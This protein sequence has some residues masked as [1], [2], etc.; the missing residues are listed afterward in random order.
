[1][2]VDPLGARLEG[3]GWRHPGRLAWAVRNATF[4]ISPG[5]RVLIAGSSGSG[6]S[7]LVRSLG[8]L[9]EPTEAGDTEGAIT[10]LGATNR[11]DCDADRRRIGFMLQDPETNLLLTKVGDDVAFGLENERIARTDIW[12]R[13]TAA[14]DDVGYGYE[15]DRPTSA[16]SGG[17]KQRVALAAMLAR[18]SGLVILDEPTAN[19]D[20]TGAHATM[21]ALARMLDESGATLVIIEHRWEMV[22]DL[23]DRVIVLTPGGVV[24]DGAPAEVLSRDPDTL[25]AHGIFLPNESVAAGLPAPPTHTEQ[26]TLFADQVSVVHRQGQPPAVDCVS[27]TSQ[28]ATASVLLGR[29]GA[30]KSTLAR[31]MGGLRKPTAGAA[32]AAGES[33]PLHRVRSRRLAALV[34]SVFQEPEHQFVASSVLDELTVGARG[35]GM[36][37]SAASERASELLTRLHLDGLADINP[38]LLSGGERRR[39]GVAAALVGSPP[40]LVADEPTFGQDANSWRDIVRLLLEQLELGTSLLIVTHDGALVEALNAVQ[41]RL[42]AGRLVPNSP[43]PPAGFRVAT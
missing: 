18:R 2:K 3:F 36:S 20:P 4:T 22:A 16:L 6:K 31:V 34:G 10:Y 32:H 41:H 37:K 15:L 5:E 38:Y 12:P 14:L 21:K 17:E 40:T 25:R 35:L 27:L 23:V 42:D 39:V 13:V 1:M 33:K 28:V 29:N 11:R 30:G 26:V 43:A 9:S 8:G 24:A 7:T 19:L